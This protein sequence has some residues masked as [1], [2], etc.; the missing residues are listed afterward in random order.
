MNSE[1]SLGLVGDRPIVAASAIVRYGF[2]VIQLP[3]QQVDAAGV[4]RHAQGVGPL[5]RA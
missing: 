2:D 4:R 5:I 3:A 1:F